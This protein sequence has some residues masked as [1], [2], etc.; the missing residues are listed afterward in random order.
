MSVTGGD[1]V[2]MTTWKSLQGEFIPVFTSKRQA[3]WAMKTRCLGEPFAMAEIKGE[4]FFLIVAPRK[5]TVIVNPGC[6]TGEVLLEPGAVQALADGSILKPITSVEKADEQV[7][8]LDP[9]DYP[10]DFI[11]PLFQFLRGRPEVQA[12][13]IFRK[14][15]PTPP[16]KIR[17]EFALHITG[18]SGQVENDFVLVARAACPLGVDFGVVVPDRTHPATIHWMAHVPPFYRRP[19]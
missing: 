15:P 10:T 4:M 13:W 6:P 11:Q 18:P 16:A 17:Y 3:T 2:A 8:I 19:S 9:A 5:Q 12:A 1:R 14:D 7:T